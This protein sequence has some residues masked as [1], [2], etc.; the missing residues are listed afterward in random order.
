MKKVKK[1]LSWV[2]LI[3]MLATMLPA[4]AFAAGGAGVRFGLEDVGGGV[5]R[6]VFQAKTPTT[7]QGMGM[8]FSY[9]KSLIQPV[10]AWDTSFD[11]DVPYMKNPDNYD[12]S[13]PFNMRLEASAPP[14]SNRS[15]VFAPT[16][17]E[18]TPD[19]AGFMVALYHPAVTRL[20]SSDGEYVDLFD[21]CFRFQDGKSP[22]DIAADTFKFETADDLDHILNLFF[23]RI[24]IC[25]GIILD[26]VAGQSQYAWGY[27]RDSHDEYVSLDEV[28]N[29]F[30]GSDPEPIVDKEALE[31]LIGEAIARSAADYTTESWAVFAGA[32]AEAQAVLSKDGATQKEVDDAVDNLRM[33]IDGL[34]KVKTIG[35][36]EIPGV[37]PPVAGGAPVRGNGERGQ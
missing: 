19:R 27:D 20:A 32:L 14:P 26:E 7:I 9:D 22:E 21:F 11:V 24:E 4:S 25:Y 34:S 12:D 29:P 6:L 35:R 13:S 18:E 5:Y 30:K 33:A 36:S 8:V 23:N 1:T 3:A 16:R 15:F 2:M 10:A 31:A 28:I 37:T 17:W